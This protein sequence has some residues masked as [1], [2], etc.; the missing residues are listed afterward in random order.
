MNEII[1]KK[2]KHATEDDDTLKGGDENVDQDLAKLSEVIVAKNGQS[3]G[4]A[5]GQNQEWEKV[6]GKGKGKGKHPHRAT[7][8]G[9]GKVG[10][11]KKGRK[12]KKGGKGKTP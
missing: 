1:D 8:A 12:G 7:P 4:A 10:K 11:G 5:L 6:K 3:P 9:K 2:I